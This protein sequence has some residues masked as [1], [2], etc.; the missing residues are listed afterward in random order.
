MT[1]LILGPCF[2]LKPS[3]QAYPSR[4]GP[5]LPAGG[6]ERASRDSA[7]AR[8]SPRQPI[9]Q[10]AAPRR[11]PSLYVD[12]VDLLPR[13]TCSHYSWNPE[14]CC[15]VVLHRTLKIKIGE[16]PRNSI[17]SCITP[18]STK[19]KALKEGHQMSLFTTPRERQTRLSLN[20]GKEILAV[21]SNSGP[22]PVHMRSSVTVPAT[23]GDS[24]RPSTRAPELNRPKNPRKF[25]PLCIT[26]QRPKT[27]ALEEGKQMNLIEELRGRT[28]YLVTIEVMALIGVTRNTLC[29]WV[30]TGK[31]SA[32]RM[33]NAY[34]FD[35][36]TLADWLEERKTKTPALRRAA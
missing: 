36:Y 18:Q 7:H 24:C 33:G 17:G 31:L 10:F 27:A 20:R 26:L 12:A 8:L 35:P 32:I 13:R 4:S 22:Q 23:D 6:W 19:A 34:L 29:D 3:L 16:N 14:L 28:T 25:N 1:E 15:L 2:S 11:F 21:S 5:G 30:R 9:K